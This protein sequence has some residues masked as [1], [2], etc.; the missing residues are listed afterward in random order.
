MC[1]RPSMA[2]AASAATALAGRYLARRSEA[3]RL[4]TRHLDARLTTWARWSD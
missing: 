3:D 4:L 1:R 2:I